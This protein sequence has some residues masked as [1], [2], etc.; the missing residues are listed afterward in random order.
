MTFK[1]IYSGKKVLITGHTGFKGSWL[2]IWLKLLGAKVIGLSLDPPTNPNNFT[3]TNIASSINDLRI[4]IRERDALAKII[5]DEHPDFIFH[6]A[7]QG[8]V[9]K[10]YKDPYETWSTNLIGT[11]NLLEA[12][13]GL[14]KSCTVVLITSDKCYKN[15]EW[16]WGYRENDLLGGKDPYSASKGAVEMAFSSYIDSF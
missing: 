1:N 8:I 9:R 7:A 15:V 6:L 3:I 2:S 16:I 10:S 14:R 5:L 11:I 4:D 12:I 13:R